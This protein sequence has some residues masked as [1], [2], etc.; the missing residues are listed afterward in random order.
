MSTQR[1]DRSSFRATKTDEG[2]LIDTPVLGRVGIQIYRNSDGSIRREYRPP[3]EVFSSGSLATFAGKPVTIGHPSAMVT[4]KSRNIVG[5]IVGD[6]F[7]DG[8]HVRARVVLHD[9]RAVDLVEKQ[10]VK[11]LSLGY[12]VEIDH[13]PGEYKGAKY[14]AIQ[15][16]VRI[17]HLAVVKEGRA[18]VARFNVDGEDMTQEEMQARLDA[19]TAERDA[20]R[21]DAKAIADK[22][23]EEVRA[24]LK[25]RLEIEAT[26]ERFG[27]VHADKADDDVM[28]A[29][30]VKA[31]PSMKLDGKDANYVRAAFDVAKD[32]KVQAVRPTGADVSYVSND[33]LSEI[34]KKKGA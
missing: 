15:R 21:D 13:T 11:E 20:L 3:E 12:T 25:N 26:A 29:V 22:I 31:L 14:D 27:V 24:E 17:N 19:V 6:A 7:Q 32:V 1:F 2:F 33:I 8:D 10:G 34:L 28:R 23:R 18:G 5:S 4:S 30:I 9:D 16:N